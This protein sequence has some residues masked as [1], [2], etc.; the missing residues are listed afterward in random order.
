MGLINESERGYYQGLDGVQLSGDENHGWYQFTSLDDIIAQFIAVYVGEDKLIRNASRTDVAFHAQRGLAEMSFDTLKSVKGFEYIVPPSLKMV[1]PQDY[2]NYVKVSWIDSA[3]VKHIIQPTHR[4]SDPNSYQQNTDGSFVFE[5]NNYQENDEGIFI[6]YGIT[7][8]G[9]ASPSTGSGDSVSSSLLPNFEKEIRIPITLSSGYAGVALNYGPASGMQINFDAP[10][11]IEVGM[12]IFG[13]GIPP[14]TTVATIGDS[15]SNN[16]SG[17]GLT[18]TN[19]LH[20]A[21]LLSGLAT[22]DPGLP[23]HSQRRGAEMIF[24]D[25][26]KK[27]TSEAAY[28]STTPVENNN[29][30]YEDDIYWP[31]NGGR[32]GLDPQ[33]AQVNGSY[34]IDT[35]AGLIHFSSNI[36]GKTVILDYISDSL[37]TDGEMQVHK[38]AEEAMY[39]WISHGILSGKANIPEYQVNRLKKERFAAVRTAKLRLSNLKLEELTQ[40]LRGKSKQIKH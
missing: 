10:H 6:D 9:L 17:M 21:W 31:A 35:V 12:T 3:G 22:P 29:N 33:H 13:P 26:N 24:V 14:R 40:I 30:D 32:Y 23:I 7:Q 18:M 34:Y 15:N 5:E 36:S 37:G 19:P 27:S 25:L 11:D 8:S 16:R 38:F 4:T 20:E 39:K 28:S 1:L 2:V